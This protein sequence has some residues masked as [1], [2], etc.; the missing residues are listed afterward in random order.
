MKYLKYL[1]LFLALTMFLTLGVACGEG[2]SNAPETTAGDGG[3]TAAPFVVKLTITALDE[4]GE[5]V[6]IFEKEDAQYNGLKPTTEL[7]IFDIVE[8]Y[9]ADNDVECTLNADGRLES[10]GGYSVAEGGFQWTYKVD[11]KKLQEYDVAIANGAK[12]EITMVV[13]D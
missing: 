1:A 13:V 4:D 10:V 9:C 7:T 12:I 5:E 11:G 8:D 6:E 2:N 3:T